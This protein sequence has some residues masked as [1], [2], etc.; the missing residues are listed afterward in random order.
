[1]V[2]YIFFLQVRSKY[3]NNRTWIMGQKGV[4][5]YAI[6]RNCGMKILIDIV[7][8]MLV[9]LCA[10]IASAN[11]G[12]VVNVG[13]ESL[14][15]NAG[16]TVAY[17]VR[18]DSISDIEEHVILS[19]TDPVEGWTYDFDTP[20]FDLAAGDS[21]TTTLHVSLPANVTPNLYESTVLGTASIPDFE[22]FVTGT[23]FFT[24]LTSISPVPELPTITLFGFGLMG[25][26]LIVRK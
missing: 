3:Q 12:I 10:N 13:P 20:A 2:D 23:S 26:L 21:F 25:L 24:F 9:L 15:A 6:L 1:M 14:V 18:T 16:Q 7:A 4:Y 19:I 17:Q 8:I 22:D 5:N 11:P